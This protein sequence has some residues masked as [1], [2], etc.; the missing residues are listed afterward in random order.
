MAGLCVLFS[1]F[2]GAATLP[3]MLDG[4]EALAPPPGGWK[5]IAVDNGST[6]GSAALLR[7][8]Q[9]RLPLTVISEPRRGKNAGLNAAL[10]SLE[11][12]LV[13]LTDDD[14]IPPPDWLVA[15]RRLA[16]ARAGFDI[17]GGA[18]RP[19]WPA[20]PPDWVL[21]RAPKGHFAW[22]EFETGP[23]E[24]RAIWGPNMAIRRAALGDRRFFEGIGPDGG[25]AY[26]T[27]SE[28]ELMLRLAA[29]GHR[30]WHE[31]DICVEHVI[32][33]RQLTAE[34]LL[35]RA[36][37]QARGEVRLGALFGD[38]RP[39]DPPLRRIGRYVSA[40]ARRALSGDPAKRFQAESRL[41]VLRGERDERRA[42]ARSVRTAR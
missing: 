4:L 6:D 34:W 5:L 1:T 14:V 27:G 7:E 35:Q 3:L 10:G 28:I 11:G 37:N 40:I 19:R 2:N 25:A 31:A 16:A 26:A 21:R 32:E 12:D 8:R 39:P 42:Q 23:V 24:P 17:F 29:A 20:P 18:I 41:A 9:S 36:Y 13:V 22:T 15:Y 33:P 30:C 38:G